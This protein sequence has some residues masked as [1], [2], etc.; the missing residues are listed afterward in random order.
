MSDFVEIIVIIG[1]IMGGIWLLGLGIWL[2]E[3]LAG[4]GYGFVDW[5]KPKQEFREPPTPSTEQLIER[6]KKDMERY[7]EELLR[8]NPQ[9]DKNHSVM[10]MYERLLQY[11][12]KNFEQL[13][14]KLEEEAEE[15]EESTI[16]NSKIR[17][18]GFDEVV[19]MPV[20]M[21]VLMALG[22]AL[23]L[24]LVCFFAFIGFIELFSL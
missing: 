4:L 6:S 5:M 17:T 23:I 3:W 13:V 1:F 24:F 14:S 21:E 18:R 15:V 11:E 9:Y 22:G 2:A 19:N 12:K 7:K 16:E 10:L 20:V 8:L